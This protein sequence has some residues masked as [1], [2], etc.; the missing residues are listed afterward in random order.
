MKNFSEITSFIW[1]V[2][3]LLRGPYKPN[4]YKDVMLPLIVLRRLDLVLEPTKEKVLNKAKTLKGTK[5]KDQ[6]M[7]SI[8]N[9][10]AKQQFHNKSEFTFEKLKADPDN[11]SA[12]LTHYINGFSERVRT[13]M[14]HFK[15]E[16]QIAKLVLPHVPKAWVDKSKT[17]IGYEINFNRYFYKYTP[18][19]PLGEI[20]KDLKSTESEIADKLSEVVK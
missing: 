5:L 2:A 12:N 11:I 14:D 17:K 7:D 13:I 6:G 3:E 4:Q 10:T 9:K 1:Q 15:F 18:H 8:L 16:D 19:R 20:E